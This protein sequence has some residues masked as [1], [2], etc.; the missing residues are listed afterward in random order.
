MSNIK[1]S[2]VI[3]AL[4]EVKQ[5]V[6]SLHALNLVYTSFDEPLFPAFEAKNLVSLGVEPGQAMFL[7]EIAGARKIS[8]ADTQRVWATATDA[9]RQIS[10]KAVRIRKEKKEIALK[11]HQCRHLAGLVNDHALRLGEPIV[12]TDMDASLPFEQIAARRNELDRLERE[13]RVRVAKADEAK[14][15]RRDAPKMAGPG[16]RRPA[17]RVMSKFDARLAEIASDAKDR[18][19]VRP[20]ENSP[21][22]E[23]DSRVA[24]SARR[25][26]VPL[27]TTEIL[28]RTGQLPVPATVTVEKP[29]RPPRV[30]RDQKRSIAACKA[31]SSVFAAIGDHFRKE[32]ER[33]AAEQSLLAPLSDEDRAT[34]TQLHEETGR[35]HDELIAELGLLSGG[36]KAA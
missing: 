24:P 3:A 26:A 8:F 33:I 4:A 30:T 23:D 18:A 17:P 16:P 25:Q 29:A 10:E 32:E 15:A 6:K 31:L 34:V 21:K 2:S 22:K 27:S 28:A 12:E 7:A 14:Q 19:D 1:T 36:S 11:I 13:L 20:E 9:Q 5:T 35:P